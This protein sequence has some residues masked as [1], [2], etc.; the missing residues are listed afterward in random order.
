MSI[1]LISGTSEEIYREIG[2]GVA[3]A[4]GYS[5]LGRELLGEAAKRYSIPEERLYRAISDAPSLLGISAK[6]RRRSIAYIQAVLAGYLKNDRLVYYSPVSHLLVR[7][8]SHILKAGIVEP[9]EIEIDRRAKTDGISRKHASRIIKREKK[10]REKWIM[11]VF[12]V[13]ESDMSHYDL[14]I[15]MSQ[16]DIEKAVELIIRTVRSP[17]FQPMTYSV[18]VMEDIELAYRVR[19]HLLDIDPEMRVESKAGVVEVYAKVIGKEKQ[20]KRKE[21]QERAMQMDGVRNVK[22][23]IG[24]DYF[25]QLAESL[26]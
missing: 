20:K 4:L 12:G 10:N 14:M 15:N 5:H 1:V 19:A 13:R 23:H 8:V 26:R 21:I 9:L 18:K 6:V 16:I 11:D 7:G 22:V 2:S 17:R 25:R 3:G 24:E